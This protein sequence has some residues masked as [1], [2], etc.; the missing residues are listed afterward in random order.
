MTGLSG[1]ARQDVLENILIPARIVP[2]LTID[3]AEDGVPLARALVAGGVKVLEVTFR[4]EAATAA[5]KAIIAQVP[6][7]IVGMGTV[8]SGGD[9]RRAKDLGARF[10]VSPG[11]TPELL[12]AA[13]TSDLP[14]LPGIATA[15]EVMQ[16]QARGFNLLKF[17]PAE[18]SG[19]VAMLRALAGPFP[20]M[21][22]C[23]T[24]GVG[25]AN[26]TMWLAES[27]VVAVGGSWLC[28]AADVKAGNWEVITGRCIDAMKKLRRR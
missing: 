16:A 5:A 6:D 10:A 15:S 18:R 4:T 22:F 13:A 14:L 8:L 1:S 26:V 7:A 25:A 28:P 21:R 19:G 20:N 9:L 2:V 12:D 3:R 11:A 27:N 23:P 17:F 24:G